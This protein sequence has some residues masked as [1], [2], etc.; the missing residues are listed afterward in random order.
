MGEDGEPIASRPDPAALMQQAFAAYERGAGGEAERLCREAVAADPDCFDAHHL[1]AVL[2]ARRGR[3]QEALAGF[4]RALALRPDYPPLMSNRGNALRALGRLDEAL[5]SFDAALARW[6]EFPQALANRGTTLHELGRPVDALAS[7]DQALALR[8]D[9]PE[10][11]VGRAETLCE[12]QRFDE[13]LASCERALAVRPGYAGAFVNR[14][15]ALM[16]LD[17]FEEA[18]ANYNQALARQPGLP[19][20][21]ANRGAP[22]RAL[23]RLGEAQATYE[24]ALGLQPENP[25]WRLDRAAIMLLRGNFSEGWR[26][27]EWRR[28]H[29]TWV[30]RHLAGLEWRG[31][32]L[33][34]KR[35][36]LYAEQGFGDTIQFARFV[37]RLA[38]RDADIA[39]EVQPALYGLLQTLAGPRRIIRQGESLP[40][41]DFHLPLMSLPALL[42]LEAADIPVEIPYLRAEP[43][44]VESWARRLPQ[45]E[46]RIGIAWQG[47]PKAEFDRRRS[48]PLAAFEPLGRIPGV[49]LISLQNHHG[50]NQLAGL[51]AGMQVDRPG[52]D[53]DAGPDS[54][55]DTAAVMTHLDLIIT[56]DTVIAHL[57]G[58]LGR[59]VWIVIRD[60]LDWRWLADRT[61]T[62]WYPTARLFR[63]GPAPG[64]SEAMGEVAAALAPLVL[65]TTHRPVTAPLRPEA[66]APAA[67]GGASMPGYV[68]SLPRRPD[69]RERFLKWNEGKGVEFVVFD[70]VDGRSLRK[71]DLIARRIVADETLG[72][73]SG[74]LGN[75]MSHRTLWETCIALGR[76]IWIFED[77][78]FLPPRIAEWVEPIN[79]E[80]AAGCDIFYLGYNRDAIVS[81]GFGDQW[82]NLAF[83]APLPPFDAAVKQVERP[84]QSS[85]RCILNTRLVWG[86][87]AYA[88]SP[89]GAEAL[90]RHCFPMS[91]KT[92]VRMFGSGQGM[93]TPYALDGIINVMI[94]Q[95]RVR[96]RTVF[97]PLVIGPNDQSDSDVVAHMTRR[98][99]GAAG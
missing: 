39:L 9:F 55:L 80:L 57:A 97:P 92:P 10:A 99:P 4:D 64:W 70:A 61:D 1:L 46:F 24:R 79:A 26:E 12:L 47:N 17:R 31:E 42:R 19:E 88:I 7:Y 60:W 56:C 30:P 75:A 59:P 94:Q 82:C 90:L 35:L 16:A 48:I 5:A 50:M 77:D 68:I 18:L 91:D 21:L 44:R 78:A 11:L 49:R 87:L 66:A 84:G 93:L 86:T 29:P 74:A 81:V 37:A 73:S 62:P 2:D 38:D 69:R 25:G 63:Q 89:A 3:Q 23:G 13:A 36:L 53:F 72:F 54:F 83:D 22:L 45:G 71:A 95:G 98:R 20:A 96:A 40:V 52:P 34:G 27:Y 65:Q 51:P 8:P 6:P 67:A 15:N 76:P 28:R 41:H 14:G 32:D 85:P 58:A 33:R 43:A